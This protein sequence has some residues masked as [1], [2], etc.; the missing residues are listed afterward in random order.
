[1]G[2]H[3]VRAS[4]PGLDPVFFDLTNLSR[5]VGVVE[6][7]APRISPANHKTPLLAPFFSDISVTLVS[8]LDSRALVPGREVRFY[9]P[10]DPNGPKASAVLEGAGSGRL[11]ALNRPVPTTASIAST[12]RRISGNDSIASV[13]GFANNVAGAYEV[14][15]VLVNEGDSLDPKQAPGGPARLDRAREPPAN[16]GVRLTPGIQQQAKAL[17]A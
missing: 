3:R 4:V 7:T 17:E 2:P 6:L 9:V 11:T 16:L 5:A 1:L 8:K 14:I 10:F 12:R 13:K 15:A